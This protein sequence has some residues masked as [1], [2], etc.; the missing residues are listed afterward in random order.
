MSAGISLSAAL[1]VGWLITSLPAAWHVLLRKQRPVSAVLWLIA[2]LALPLAG[3]LL[4]LGFGITRVGWRPEVVL[5]KG[6]AARLAIAPLVAEETHW[7]LRGDP[8]PHLGELASLHTVLDRLVRFPQLRGN[9]LSP[10]RGWDQCFGEMLAAIDAAERFVLLQ[11]YIFNTDAVGR[12]FLDA[13][14]RSAARGVDC[15]VL[16]DPVGSM[17]QDSVPLQRAVAAGVEL[18]PLASRSWLRGRFQINLRNHRK[19]LVV[20][21]RRGFTGGVNI[22]SAHEAS[23]GEPPDARDYHFA[24]A[25]PVVQQ[26]T[27]TFLEDWLH[28]T[29]RLLVDAGWFPPAAQAGDAV[30]RAIPS[31]PDADHEIWLRTLLAALGTARRRL[32][33]A[34]P[35]FVPGNS[36]HDALALAALRGV[37]VQVLVPERCDHFFV[38]WASQAHLDPLLEAGVEIAA[39]PAPFLHA[40]LLIVDEG[41]ASV[42]S[43]NIDNRSL[44]L[45]YEFNLGV[46]SRAEVA[47]IGQLFDHEWAASRPLDLQERR[48]RGPAIRAWENLWALWSPLL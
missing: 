44:R 38:H 21:G 32:R 34:T 5:E 20:D 29:G 8:Q 33:I 16:F 37:R 7:V 10:L 11:S 40:K 25:G 43:A 47:T 19:I 2:T 46:A 39:R 14:S 26:L 15:R 22:S 4:Y 13:L 6:R 3:P 30:L 42:G 23:A 12:R 9:S 45:N 41:W 48:L 17:A 18:R 27:A 36:L 24:V 31:G 1:G 35:Y 28:A